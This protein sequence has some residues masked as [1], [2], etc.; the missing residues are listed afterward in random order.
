MSN[1]VFNDASTFCTALSVKPRVF[2]VVW[3]MAGACASEPWPTA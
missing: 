1:A 2:S 3:L